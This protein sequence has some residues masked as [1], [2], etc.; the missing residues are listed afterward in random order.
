MGE[1]SRL[2]LLGAAEKEEMRQRVK[3]Y[4]SAIDDVPNRTVEPGR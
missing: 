3:D 4:N 2:G 1:S